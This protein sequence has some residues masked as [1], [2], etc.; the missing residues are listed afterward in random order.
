ML[1]PSVNMDKL[2]LLLVFFCVISSSHCAEEGES[3]VLDLTAD[4]FNDAITNNPVILVEF[5][6]PW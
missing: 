1:R 5:F 6:A 3:A 2:C 4:T